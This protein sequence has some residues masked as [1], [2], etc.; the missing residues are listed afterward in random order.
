VRNKLS[1]REG[2]FGYYGVDI[3]ID[4]QLNCWLLEINSGP[5][6]DMTNTALEKVIPMCLNAAISMSK[7]YILKL[8][9]NLFY[10][11]SH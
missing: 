3:L 1:I 11:C 8:N 2:C 7:L 10:R 5:T 6:L 4:E 9:L